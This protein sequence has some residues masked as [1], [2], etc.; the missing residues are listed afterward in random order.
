[1]KFSSEGLKALIEI[2]QINESGGN[3]LIK[4]YSVIAA[5]I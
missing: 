1:M 2:L 4:T 3:T 5:R